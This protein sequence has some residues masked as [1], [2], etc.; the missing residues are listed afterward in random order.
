ML[1]QHVH[2]ICAL[3]ACPQPSQLFPMWLLSI[4]Y[5]KQRIAVQAH[6]NYQQLILRRE[7]LLGHR[8]IEF[9]ALPK[10]CSELNMK[11]SSFAS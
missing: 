1:A 3:Q 10:F 7:Y 2:P 4:H 8:V 9:V 6:I 11:S 5:P